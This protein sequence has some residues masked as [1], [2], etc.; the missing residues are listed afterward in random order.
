Q[1][2]ARPGALKM[3]RPIRHLPGL[4]VDLPCASQS[5]TIGKLHESGIQIQNGRAEATAEADPRDRKS[6][7]GQF[8]AAQIEFSR[9]L[10]CRHWPDSDLTLQRPPERRPLQLSKVE[11]NAQRRRF[12]RQL[13]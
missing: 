9:R 10:A 3:P 2:L 4:Q 7:T 11:C 12:G 5:G 1:K 8:F 6:T 13:A